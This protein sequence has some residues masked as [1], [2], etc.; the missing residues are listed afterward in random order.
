[1]SAK[2]LHL[3]QAVETILTPGCVVR[4]FRKR[5][6]PEKNYH[7]PNL[8]QVLSVVVVVDAAVGELFPQDRQRLPVPLHGDLVILRFSNEHVHEGRG[9]QKNGDRLHLVRLNEP[10]EVVLLLGGGQ[11]ELLH[12]GRRSCGLL[13]SC[14][15]V[16]IDCLVRCGAR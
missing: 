11:G 10:I 4:E 3:E 5:C 1:M 16:V 14:G 12:R 6:Q 9:Q 13:G 2:H 8:L 15:L 7:F